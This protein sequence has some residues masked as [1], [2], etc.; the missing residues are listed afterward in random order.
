MAE[1]LEVAT[2]IDVQ[3]GQLDAL[4]GRIWQPVGIM[5]YGGGAPIGSHPEP[6]SRPR[7]T[8]QT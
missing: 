4:Y 5:R 3:M 7:L 8:A 1:F 2:R 6:G